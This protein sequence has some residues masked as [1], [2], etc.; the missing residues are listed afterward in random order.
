MLDK[1]VNSPA[2]RMNTYNGVHI[3]AYQPQV[4]E[5]W[6]T[7]LELFVAQR[8]PVDRPVSRGIAPQLYDQVFGVQ[9]LVVDASRFSGEASYD[10]AV[11]RW[12]AEPKLRAL[13]ESGAGGPDDR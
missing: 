5:E 2:V 6:Y 8:V 11:A 3:D 1:F 13:F 7:F 12:K 9:D 10:A 4:L